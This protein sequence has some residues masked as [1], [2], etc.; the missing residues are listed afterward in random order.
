M[1]EQAL[2]QPSEK[3]LEM[4]NEF[5]KRF[6]ELKAYFLRLNL[7]GENVR[8]AVERLDDGFLRAR[9]AIFSLP[10]VTTPLEDDKVPGETV[11]PTEPPLVA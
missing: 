7:P 11:P 9:E 2:E 1:T 10:M 6:M 4:L 8:L 5:G 3:H